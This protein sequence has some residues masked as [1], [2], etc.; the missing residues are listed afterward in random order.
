MLTLIKL[1]EIRIVAN[2]C[3]GI[4]NRRIIAL[5]FLLF[6]I[7]IL[8]ISDGEREKNAVSDPEIKPENN[9]N[10]KIIDNANT[11]PPVNPRKNCPE[12]IFKQL[13]KESISIYS[14]II[15]YVKK[16]L[17]KLQRKIIP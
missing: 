6:L 1:F 13:T 2:N 7:F 11:I 9:S 12:T 10:I 3:F 14:K 16:T 15:F 4:V 5:S 17:A 8:S